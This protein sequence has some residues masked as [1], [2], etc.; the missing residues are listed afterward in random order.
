MATNLVTCAIL[1]FSGLVC[2]GIIWEEIHKI[3]NSPTGDKLNTS[4]GGP[5]G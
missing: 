5:A 1:V 2:A 4:S 3:F